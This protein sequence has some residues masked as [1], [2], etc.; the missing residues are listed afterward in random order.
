MSIGKQ[1]EYQ[2]PM[3]VTY[4]QIPKGLGHVFYDRLQRIFASCEV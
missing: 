2:V 4:D 3:W 1:T